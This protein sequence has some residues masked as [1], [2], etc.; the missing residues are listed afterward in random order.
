MSNELTL[1]DEAI[2]LHQQIGMY[3]DQAQ[4][5]IYNMGKCMYEMKEK[6][7][8][9]QI[10]YET[11]DEYCKVEFD[12]KKS[13]SSKFISIYKNLGENY[14]Q[15]NQNIGVTKL[16]M[17]SQIAPEDREVISEENELDDISVKELEEQIKQ[18][19]KEKE[20]AQYKLFEITEENEKV[21]KELKTIQDKPV[22]VAVSEPDPKEIEARAEE[23]ATEKTIAA[24]KR[25][26]DL[27]ERLEEQEKEN[28]KIRSQLETVS[29][30][31]Y[32]NEML[33][34]KVKELEEKAPKICDPDP[35]E[36]ETMAE[37][38][39][40]E[41]IE[42]IQKAAKNEVE[43]VK[44]DFEKKL[45]NILAASAAAKENEKSTQVEPDQSLPVKEQFK[46]YLQNV[47]TLLNQAIEF[48][49][50]TEQSEFL[51]SQLKSALQKVGDKI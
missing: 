9:K 2:K 49:N 29:K 27:S 33:E 4:V 37:E 22:D 11:F 20:D 5:A 34:K 38:I 47:I 42:E 7:L 44:A 8:Y 26:E 50:G 18:L 17:L 41:K 39:A 31:T 25:M 16:Y 23:I 35:L 40:N 15:E 12:L 24:R 48:A 14:I 10:G 36:V 32:D 51:L 43:Q 13:Q 30:L 21:K 45:Q 28:R 46:V 3:A 19:Q 1:R 6:S